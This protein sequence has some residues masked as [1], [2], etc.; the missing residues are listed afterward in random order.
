M[1]NADELVDLLTRSPRRTAL[2]CDF[3]GTLSPIVRDP[4]AA[5]PVPGAVDALVALSTRLL[6]V[7]VLSGRPLRYLDPLIPAE[8]D[9]AALYGLEQRVGGQVAEHPAAGRW[10]P[11]ISALVIEA[12]AAFA[13]LKGVTVEP[14]GLSLTL[15]CR[16]APAH[17]AELDA[18]AA[19]VARRSGLEARPAKASVELHPPVAVDKGTVLMA[20]AAGAETAVFFGDDVGDLPAFAALRAGVAAGRLAHAIGV[21][22]VGDE[23]PVEVSE[24]ADVLL[25][26]P[27][28][29]AEVLMRTARALA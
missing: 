10:R 12:E 11:I 14:K 19:D 5:R 27:A 13:G 20:W 1:L 3:D 15:H 26:G 22:A 29:V 7:A 17:A 2:F 28:A 6:R 18:W 23:T 9:V 16:N 25:G 8:V 4:A 21:V 24:S